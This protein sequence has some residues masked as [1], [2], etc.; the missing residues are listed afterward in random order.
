MS[1][2][3][4]DDHISSV[5][6]NRLALRWALKFLRSNGCF[7]AWAGKLDSGSITISYY[8]YIIRNH[9]NHNF[10]TFVVNA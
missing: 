2:S 8:W 3:K 9:D 1:G 5:E 4:I 6:L 7:V 10:T